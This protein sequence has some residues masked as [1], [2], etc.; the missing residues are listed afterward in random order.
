MG[1]PD[2]GGKER[3]SGIKRISGIPRLLGKPRIS[4]TRRKFG[5]PSNSE[6]KSLSGKIGIL[7]MPR[8]QGIIMISGI[9]ISRNVPPFFNKSMR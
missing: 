4:K 6:M 3:I 8:I 9:S 1:I 5:I 7:W 2:I